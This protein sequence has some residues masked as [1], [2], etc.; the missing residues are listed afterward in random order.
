[1]GDAS[2]PALPDE[3]P[4]GAASSGPPPAASSPAPP[5]PEPLEPELLELLELPA[6]L[7]LDEEVLPAIP[8]E[9]PDGIVP[10]PASEQPPPAPAAPTRTHK[11]QVARTRKRMPKN[12][13]LR[14]P[15]PQWRG[16]PPS[17]GPIL[18]SFG[19]AASFADN[20]EEH[21]FRKL[22]R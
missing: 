18:A 21:A 20:P 8:L 5:D 13:L 11:T 6:E 12:S 22:Q 3:S 1:L 10:V 9:L 14:A 16:V 15:S 19:L 17:A 2:S 7:P 4:P